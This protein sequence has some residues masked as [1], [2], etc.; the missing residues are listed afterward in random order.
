MCV[1]HIKQPINLSLRSVLLGCV[2]ASR[3]TN[4]SPRRP[5]PSVAAVCSPSRAPGS[6]PLSHAVSVWTALS[7]H[8]TWLCANE[9]LYVIVYLWSFLN[10]LKSSTC[11]IYTIPTQKYRLTSIEMLEKN[12][13]L[14]IALSCCRYS[15][16][17][18]V[19]T[20]IRCV[21]FYII[22]LLNNFCEQHSVT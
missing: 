14:T 9:F 20:Q 21:K 12:I 2:G 11:F 1:R 8:V 16:W 6:P 18:W 17:D 13:K 15:P 7:L 3:S 5:P 19:W 22:F 10:S 4:Q